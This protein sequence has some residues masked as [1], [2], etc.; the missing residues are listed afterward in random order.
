MLRS[1]SHRLAAIA[2]V[3]FALGGCKPPPEPKPTKS[4]KQVGLEQEIDF[5]IAQ[6]EEP[7]TGESGADPIYRLSR[8]GGKAVPKLLEALD[9]RRENVRSGA[10]IILTHIARQKYGHRGRF[11]FDAGAPLQDRRTG[12]EQFKSWWQKVSAPPEPS[13]KPEGSPK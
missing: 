12:V 13:P 4:P 9:A 6:L 3:V 11:D 8:L 1:H 10:S 5:L 7:S 2:A